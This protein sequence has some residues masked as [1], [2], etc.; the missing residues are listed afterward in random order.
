[1]SSS[2]ADRLA[3]E[4]KNVDTLHLSWVCDIPEEFLAGPGVVRVA[5]GPARSWGRNRV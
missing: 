1:M 3:K 4:A 5:M 2:S